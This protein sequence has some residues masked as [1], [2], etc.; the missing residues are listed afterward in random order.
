LDNLLLAVFEG[1]VNK[2]SKKIKQPLINCIMEIFSNI[3]RDNAK[4]VCSQIWLRL[5]EF[6]AAVC[7]FISYMS[8]YPQSTSALPLL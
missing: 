8:K 4:R 3:S 1:D 5:E 2:S 6:V 7:D